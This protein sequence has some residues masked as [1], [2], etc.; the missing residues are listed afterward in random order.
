VKSYYVSYSHT[1]AE[2]ESLIL[3]N[4]VAAAYAAADDAD[5]A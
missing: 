1:S 5:D 2:G 3:L 4:D